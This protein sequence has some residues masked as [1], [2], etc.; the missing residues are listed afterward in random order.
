MVKL[1]P[2]QEALHALRWNLSRSELPVAAQLD[3]AR[4]DPGRK[5]QAA[6]GRRAAGIPAAGRVVP[7]ARWY[8]FALVT[9]ILGMLTGFYGTT[10]QPSLSFTSAT[11]QP[12]G[13]YS[14]TQD[15]IIL[16]AFGVLIGGAWLTLRVTAWFAKRP[17]IAASAFG[18]TVFNRKT[19]T[20][21]WEDVTD[22]VLTSVT[23]FARRGWV[24]GIV[25]KDGHVLPVAFAEFLPSDGH[26][27]GPAPEMPTSGGVAEV[28]A[29]IREGLDAHHQAA[30]QAAGTV[31]DQAVHGAKA[32]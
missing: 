3:D 5:R 10:R 15:L 12:Q 21:P 20:L 14:A 31:P 18:V 9:I 32:G 28:S 1:T 22:V 16:A 24:P 26:A 2:V 29:L 30:A 27:P 25:R 6:V 8:R 23:R 17:S 4:L 7:S 11:S 19:L 13:N